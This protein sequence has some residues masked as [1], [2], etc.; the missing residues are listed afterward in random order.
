MK[1]TEGDLMH[2]ITLSVEEFILRYRLIIILSISSIAVLAGA[3]FSVRGIINKKEREAENDFGKV[4]ARYREE[5]AK[6]DGGDVT[7]LVESF[8]GVLDEH[9]RT[10]AASKAAYFAGN[11]LYDEGS[12]EEALQHYLSGSEI[13]PRQYSALLCMTRAGAC[14]EQ[15][16]RYDEA[17]VVYR[18]IIEN[19]E[20]YFIVPTIIYELAQILEQ[21]DRLDEAEEQYQRI[22]SDYAWSS[23]SELAESKLLYLKSVTSS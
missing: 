16:E 5:Q 6:E 7:S 18:K 19:Y 9:P 8:E 1:K 4:Y 14:F 11:I 20:D 22:V 23:W 21:L 10:A 2:R 12:Y 15:L 3:Y 13:K 17:V